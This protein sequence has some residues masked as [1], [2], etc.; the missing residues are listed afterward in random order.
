[1]RS[2]TLGGQLAESV[3]EWLRQCGPLPVD[4]MIPWPWAPVGSH[5]A[6]GQ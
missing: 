1:M 4:G 5:A 6:L 2:L 3:D